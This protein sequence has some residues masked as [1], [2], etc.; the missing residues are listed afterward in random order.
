MALWLVRGGRDGEHEA[1]FFADSRIY[2]TWEDGLQERNLSGAKSYEEIKRIV[3]ESYPGESPNKLTNH[4]GQISAF[5]LPMKAGDFVALPRKRRAMIAIGELTGP[6]TYDAKAEQPYRHSRAVRWLN[7][8]VPRSA[9]DQDLLYSLGA[10]MSVCQITRNNAEQRVRAMAQGGWVAKA[11]VAPPPTTANEASEADAAKDLGRLGR[12]QIAQLINRKFKGHDMTRL[13]E[14]I[15]A[16]QGYVTYVSPPG[17]DRGVDILAAPAPLGFG[18]P[19]IC[20][21]VKSQDSPV[22]SPTLHQLVGSMQNVQADQGL[23]V[24]WGGWKSSV[25]R[26]IPNQFFRVRLWD[27]E[28]LIDQL[29]SAYEKLPE[30]L[31]A[32]IPLK[33]VWTIAAQE[34]EE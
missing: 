10:F 22:D 33:R 6:Y 14:A 7:T 17:P 1:K 27:Q 4:S 26:E 31:R 19:R 8:D 30:D 24:A 20:V 12:D 9:F 23:L 18:R 32:E 16:S 29:L 2:L 28:D 25:E 5:A 34:D 11:P 15:L 3:F 21:Q 13:V